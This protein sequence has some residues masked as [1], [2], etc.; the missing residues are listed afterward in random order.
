MKKRIKPQLSN[1]VVIGA[2]GLLLVVTLVMA[3]Y[4][5]AIRRKATEKNGASDMAK[6]QLERLKHYVNTS[7][8]PLPKSGSYFCMVSDSKVQE[9]THKPSEDIRRDSSDYPKPCQK[10]SYVMY[11]ARKG[12][13]Y[14]VHVRWPA[15]KQAKK[16]EYTIVYRAYQHTIAPEADISR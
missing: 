6:V 14:T 16:D 15:A 7:T 5:A 13:A 12:A 2:L 1:R 10:D 11:I 9:L 4:S 3:Q 8:D